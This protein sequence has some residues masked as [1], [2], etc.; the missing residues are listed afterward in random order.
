[1]NFPDRHL[2]PSRSLSTGGEFRGL[3]DHFASQE[4]DLDRNVPELSTHVT[5][6]ALELYSL[7]AMPPDTECGGLAQYDFG[8][9]LGIA[10][11]AK[12]LQNP[13]R[14]PFFHDGR[15]QRGIKCPYFYHGLK[16][17]GGMFWREIIEIAAEFNDFIRFSGILFHS[18]P[19]N[20][21][22]N[23]GPV[24]GVTAS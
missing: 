1:M 15:R 10:L 7:Q 24:G 14:T 12:N 18:L 13:A 5:M 6:V 9:S 3:L 2:M 23:I 4:S 20:Q 19:K 22:K 8:K 17:A 21:A 16:G 11:P